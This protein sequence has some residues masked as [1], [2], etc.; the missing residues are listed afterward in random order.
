MTLSAWSDENKFVRG[1]V[2]IMALTM[3]FITDSDNIDNVSLTDFWSKY[4]SQVII[5][6]GVGLGV[7]IPTIKQWMNQAEPQQ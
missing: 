4:R 1:I 6:V 5:D 2:M 3:A 7:T